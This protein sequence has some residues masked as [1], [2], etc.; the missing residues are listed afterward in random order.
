MKLP[1]GE[2]AVVDIQKLRD[3]CLNPH[4]LRGRHKAR[5]FESALGMTD[6]S[7][8]ILREALLEAARTGNA[9]PG[10][11]DE[12]GERYIIDFPMHGLRGESQVRSVWI[13]L[14]RESFPHLVTCYVL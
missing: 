3:Y 2:H 5:V 8:E 11:K 7:A 13:V 1:N 4:H 14:R 10:V 6:A 9:A 12:Y